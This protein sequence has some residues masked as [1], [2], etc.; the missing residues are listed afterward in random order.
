M[1]TSPESPS[2]WQRSSVVRFFRWLCS[3]QGARRL[4][5]ILAWA[6][7]LVALFYAEE[8]WRGRTAWNNYRRQLPHGGTELDM[9]TYIP[10]PV[11]DAQNL[12]SLPL[13]RNWFV[14]R[15]FTDTD[16]RWADPYSGAN[17]LLPSAPKKEPAHRTLTD[18]VAWKAAFV[19]AATNGTHNVAPGALD[20]ASRA[21][22]APAVLEGLKTNETVFVEL[23]AAS[24]RSSSVYPVQYD[25]DI[26]SAILL[27]H[28]ANVKAVCGRL[29]LKASAELALGQT[30]AALDDI[31]LT[32][33]MADSVKQ[34]PIL[35]SQLVR[36]ASFNL[37]ARPVWEGF[38]EHRWSEPQLKR[39]ES[40]FNNF[41][42]LPETELAM[43][44]ERSCVLKTIEYVR[45]HRT[46]MVLFG[47]TENSSFP[48]VVQ[49]IAW[50][51]PSGWYRKEQLN[52]AL[53]AET[54]LQD[55]FDVRNRRVFPGRVRA[56]EQAF[57]QWFNP[58][59][60]GTFGRF[61]RHQ[62]AVQIMAPAWARA[63]QRF[64]GA[65]NIAN[66]V[67]VACAL[68]QFRLA[69]GEYP[70]SLQQAGSGFSCDIITGQPLKYKRE[71]KDNY[72]LYSVGWDEK[73]DGGT[74]GNSVDAPERGDWVWEV[75]ARS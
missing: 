7:T 13:I 9:A 70:E 49:G 52:Y 25:L 38:A 33:R 55:T 59:G 54:A 69:H 18:L 26:P 57:N 1:K 32:L 73:D 40:S 41:G 12:C 37:A 31:E 39:L 24:S 17:N 3:W 74:P 62:T 63:L 47:S 10:K 72:V 45:Q 66:E 56:N 6:V 8:N 29:Q 5:I 16:N 58:E 42:F 36:I 2:V 20:A 15:T 44:G 19:S 61:F 64:A 14:K 65:Q 30:D 68:E 67:V 11:P 48:A 43:D 75:P 21:A 34:E 71:G 28:L 51:M 50:L 4:L 27:P 23:R 60:R 35:I 46:T 53:A 22:A